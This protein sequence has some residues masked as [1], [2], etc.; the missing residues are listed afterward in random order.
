MSVLL[1][2]TPKSKQPQDILVCASVVAVRLCIGDA[3]AVDAF[4]TG[5]NVRC[6][7]VFFS[8]RENFC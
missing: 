3:S 1:L 2:F 7:I 4:K 5:H 8:R 6:V